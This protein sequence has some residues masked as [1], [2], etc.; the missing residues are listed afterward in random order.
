MPHTYS[1]PL[2]E[3]LTENPASPQVPMPDRGNA[4]YMGR[5]ATSDSAGHEVSYK[6][7]EQE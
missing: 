1:G 2:T 7:L 6:V 5:K 4:S 3:N